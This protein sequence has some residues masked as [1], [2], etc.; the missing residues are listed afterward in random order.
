MST[1]IE[2]AGPLHVPDWATLR[3]ALWPGGSVA[4]HVAD[5][6]TMLS[7]DRFAAFVA[8]HDGRLVGFAEAS[9]RHDHVN[10]CDTTPVTFLEGIYVAPPHR[11]TGIASAL[12][13][14]V[15]DW[16]RAAG[17]GELAT[18][19]DLAHADAHAFHRGAGFT[20]TE[21]VVFFRRAL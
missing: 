3:V 9:I 4:D 10:G 20:E 11:R 2:T 18:D 12:T 5:L 1:A 16:G 19:S 6:H 13:T 14:V 17:C 15:A 7:D 8:V 21:R